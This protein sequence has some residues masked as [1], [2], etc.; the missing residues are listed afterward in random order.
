MLKN[1]PALWG[2]KTKLMNTSNRMLL[3]S[4]NRVPPKV[5]P[6]CQNSILMYFAP[7]TRIIICHHLDAKRTQTSPPTSDPTHPKLEHTNLSARAEIGLF[8]F[9][10]PIQ[11]MLLACLWRKR[12]QGKDGLLQVINLTTHRPSH[13]SL[14]YHITITGTNTNLNLSGEAVLTTHPHGNLVTHHRKR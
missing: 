5:I 9:L 14:S 8:K 11:G 10:L 1:I 6:R 3:L 12:K 2:R 7:Q 4:S 13:P